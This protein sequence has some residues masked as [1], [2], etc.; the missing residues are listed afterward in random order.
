MRRKSFA[1]T[2]CPIAR[3]VDLI[4]DAWSLLILRHALLGAR[5]FQEFEERLGIAPTTLTRKLAALS[6]AGLLERRR[7]NAR[8]PRETYELTEQALDFLPVLIALAAW[9]NRWLAHE[10]VAIQC[11]DPASGRTLDPVLI[12]RRSGRVLRAGSVAIKAG[13]AAKR[14]LRRALQRP[15]TFGASHTEAS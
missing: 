8:P 14:Q 9:G 13:P 1:D 6:Q 15:V 2:Q 4:G 10:G 3:S 5:R 11:V 7:Y 12:D